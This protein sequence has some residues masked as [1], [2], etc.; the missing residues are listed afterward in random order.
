MNVNIFFLFLAVL[1][2]SIY[3]FFKPLYIQKKNFGNIPVFELKDF[4]L[5]ELNTSGLTTLMTGKSATKYEDKYIVKSI[6]FTDNSKSKLMSVKAD[7]GIYKE[8]NISLAGSIELFQEDGFTF[9]TEHAFYNRKNSILN[10][11]TNYTARKRND[12]FSGSSLI[13][14]NLLDKIKSKNIYII[15]QLEESI[16]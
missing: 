7:N 14:N 10:I 6:N 13:Y 2:L 9:K 3:M 1:L 16:Q 11:D 15:Y 5:Y 8:D 12:K 4:E